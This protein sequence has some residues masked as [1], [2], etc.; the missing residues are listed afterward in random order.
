MTFRLGILLGLFV[1]S[2]A[3]SYPFDDTQADLPNSLYLE[4]DGQ[5]TSGVVETYVIPISD[6]PATLEFTAIGADGGRAK[7]KSDAGADK[8][9]EGGGGASITATFTVDPYAT[10]ALRPGGE[11]RFIVGN[12]GD[13]TSKNGAAFS[14]GGGGTGIIYRA[15][16]AGAGWDPLIIAG[17]GGGG[18]A[19]AN[20]D[21]SYG[22]NGGN[23]NT[24]TYGDNSAVVG[25]DDGSG[26]GSILNEAGGGGGWIH[27][28]STP[29]YA[30]Q[31]G[32]GGDATGGAGGTDGASDGDGGFGCG[33]GGTGYRNSPNGGG[34]GGGGYSGGGAGDVGNNNDEAGGGGG[35]YIDS[36]A[37]NIT[38]V[39]RSSGQDQQGR[40]YLESTPVAGNTLDDPT[41]T[42]DPSGDVEI[43]YADY[44]DGVVASLLPEYSAADLYNNSVDVSPTY[45]SYMTDGIPGSYVTAYYSSRDQFG[46]NT[47]TAQTITLLA[48]ELPTFSL[49]DG[50]TV[51]ED[52]GAYSKD[53]FA[54]DL[55]TH[56]DEVSFSSF[57]VTN[58]N[59]GLFSSQ[60]AISA[61]GT[62]TFTPAPDAYGTALV[63]V[64]GTTDIALTDY[65]DSDPVTFTIEVTHDITDDPPTDIL[66]SKNTISENSTAVGTVSAADPAGGTLSY[67][68]G[69]DNDSAFFTIDE[70]SGALA[71]LN[72]PSFETPQ[73]ADVDNTYHVTVVVT[74]GGTASITFEVTVE[75]VNE[76]PTN[77]ALSN[78]S[79]TENTT[80]VGTVSGVDPAGGT[81]SY[82][83][84]GD[85]RLLFEISS[86]G[87]LSFIEAPDFESPGDV[88]TD[89]VY[90][91]TIRVTGAESSTY[92]AY[93][94]T[95][96]NAVEGLYNIQLSNNEVAENTTSVGAISAIDEAGGTPRYILSGRSGDNSLFQVGYSSGEV[97]F[98]TAP[99]FEAPGDQNGDNV[100]DI[101]VAIFGNNVTKQQTFEITVTDAEESPLDEF[102]S[103]YSL[104]SDGSD[105]DE[106]WSQNGI[107]NLMYLAF[108]LGDPNEMSIDNSRL[109]YLEAGE[110]PDTLIF[111]YVCPEVVDSGLSFEMETSNDFS[112][113]HA[114]EALGSEYEAVAETEESL[115]DDYKRV[116]LTYMIQPAEAQRFYRLSVSESPGS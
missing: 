3:F 111:S 80:N 102:R 73:D 27:S 70:T 75:D 66:L 18:A 98:K 69:T 37:T 42:L 78:D 6:W 51:G 52:S 58:N 16:V 94:I 113:W 10:D 32:N 109:P 44:R 2:I 47:F 17:G 88:D 83:V 41:I 5:R 107:T 28:S 19:E 85:D 50:P 43:A 110:D 15:P 115:G 21:A 105:N 64:V 12:K 112:S 56:Y 49:L 59:N 39:T 20:L 57:T 100:Y 89:N 54:Y 9:G 35:S 8:T 87:L 38:A 65:A 24:E 108:G 31:G 82:L 116:K 22:K 13:S 71:F 36:R 84:L 96:T 14:G 67:S 79:V 93:N 45:N 62:L 30:G 4:G 77:I 92:K 61:D 23:A 106:D 72:A 90:S 29:T 97:S 103:T 76:A 91:I 53:D 55:E 46:N 99:D 60:P 26:G 95:V 34:G 63:T 114:P 101:T 104:A 1:P 86:S 7:A 68:I 81:L 33:G 40:V 25:G 74:G 11:I 48:P